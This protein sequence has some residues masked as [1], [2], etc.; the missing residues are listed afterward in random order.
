[1]LPALGRATNFD[2][3]KNL[4]KLITAFMRFNFYILYKRFE[5]SAAP[6]CNLHDAFLLKNQ[7]THHKTAPLNA[8]DRELHIIA[9]AF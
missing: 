8:G 2:K 9:D 1:L 7:I 6:H 3:K 5:I 4:R